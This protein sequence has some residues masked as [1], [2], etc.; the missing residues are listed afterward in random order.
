MTDEPRRY[1]IE[2]RRPDREP[3]VVGHAGTISA[4][5]GRLETAMLELRRA[6]ETGQVVLVAEDG[7]RDVASRKIESPW[8]KVKR[9][10]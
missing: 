6:G 3:M 5:L 4:G 8:A 7:D 9:R 10:T 1:R 2:H